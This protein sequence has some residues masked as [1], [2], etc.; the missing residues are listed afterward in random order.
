MAA[1]TF[2]LLA[3]DGL[4]SRIGVTRE[5]LSGARLTL[6]SNVQNGGLVT[7]DDGMELVERVIVDLDEDGKINGDTGI[8]L[9]AD[10]ESLNVGEPLKWQANLTGVAVQ[11]FP[12]IV[13]P[14]WFRAPENGETLNLASV[15]PQSNTAGVGWRERLIDGGTPSSNGIES[16]DGGG[17]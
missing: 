17:I 12:R 11:G 14:F 6:R 13:R 2:T 7:V 8:V 9:L 3:G 4:A 15:V 16:A 5:A 1:P 10:A